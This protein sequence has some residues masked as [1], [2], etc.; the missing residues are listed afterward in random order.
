MEYVGRLD[1]VRSSNCQTLIF[2]VARMMREADN[3]QPDSEIL[4]PF[5]DM[6]NYN[7]GKVERSPDW[8]SDLRT[9]D[10]AKMGI[11]CKYGAKIGREMTKS[12]LAIYEQLRENTR[13]K[14]EL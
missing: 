10:V 8:Y 13:A 9:V 2:H 5:L 3:V 7:P 1:S 11:Y 4:C 14:Q 6:E 12:I